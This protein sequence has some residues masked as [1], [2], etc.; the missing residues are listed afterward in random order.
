MGLRQQPGEGQPSINAREKPDSYPMGNVRTSF[1]V[2]REAGP[3]VLS[4]ECHLRLEALY[5]RLIV[6]SGDS[7][8]PGPQVTLTYEESSLRGRWSGMGLESLRLARCLTTTT[9]SIQSVRSYWDHSRRTPTCFY[10]TS[11]SF[12]YRAGI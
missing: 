12:A 10:R 1:H 4:L 9:T 3:E 8:I 7:S 5:F 2:V 11:R 6:P